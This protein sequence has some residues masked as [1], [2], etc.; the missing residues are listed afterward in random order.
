MEQTKTLSLQR[1]SVFCWETK[2]PCL[3]CKEAFQPALQAS[4]TTLG[5]SLATQRWSLASALLCRELV[6]LHCLLWT[7]EHLKN[8]CPLFYEVA[9]PKKQGPVCWLHEFA[10]GAKAETCWDSELGNPETWRW[11]WRLRVIPQKMRWEKSQKS[12]TFFPPVL[13]PCWVFQQPCKQPATRAPDGPAELA[14]G[15]WLES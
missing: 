11:L 12:A 4:Q 14:G 8:I 3:M 7:F 6:T 13:L 2:M 1:I 9:S 15:G 10:A 5:S